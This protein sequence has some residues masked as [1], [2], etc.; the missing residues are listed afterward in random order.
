MTWPLGAPLARGC[1]GLIVGLMPVPE[2]GG[3]DVL[4][5]RQKRRLSAL[6]LV[7]AVVA[8]AAVPGAAAGN[9]GPAGRPLRMN[10]IQVIGTHNSY[11]RELSKAERAAHDAVY[12]GAPVYQGF[13]AYSHASLPNRLSS[14][15][16]RGLELDLYPDPSGGLYSNPLLRE[17][18]ALGSLMDRDWYRRASRCS[19]PPTSTTTRPACGWSAACGSCGIGRGPIPVTCRCS[20]HPGLAERDLT[21]IAVHV[22]PDRP[23]DRTAHDNL[24][25]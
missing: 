20:H 15:R 24:L 17:R 13:L 8:V 10:E 22:Q 4:R 5:D 6:M 18:L 1:A 12:G 21:E 25:A 16:V 19:I 23:P 7:L 14:Q 11:H 3:C 2:L 9:G